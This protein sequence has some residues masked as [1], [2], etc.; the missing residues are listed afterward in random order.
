MVFPFPSV[1]HRPV[2]VLLAQPSFFENFLP[3]TAKS[4]RLDKV[5]PRA[6]EIQYSFFLHRIVHMEGHNRPLWHID[7]FWIGRDNPGKVFLWHSGN[8]PVAA[9][10]LSA[11]QFSMNINGGHPGEAVAVENGNRQNFS[12]LPAVWRFLHFYK[13]VSSHNYLSSLWRKPM[14]AVIDCRSSALRLSVW[15][16]DDS[17]ISLFQINQRFFPTLGA[18]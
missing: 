3:K 15:L 6:A 5:Q 10:Y 7:F 14:M 17:D 13:N 16:F 2:P 8:P 18:E 4:P 9:A 11:I 1:P 12:D